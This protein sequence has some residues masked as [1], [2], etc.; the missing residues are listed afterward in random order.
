MW[1]ASGAAQWSVWVWWAVH[2]IAWVPEAAFLFGLMDLAGD[3]VGCMLP[4]PLSSQRLLMSL[5]VDE[6]LPQEKQMILAGAGMSWKP[7][8]VTRCLSL[9]VPSSPSLLLVPGRD[10]VP[11]TIEQHRH[12]GGGRGGARLV[13]GLPSCRSE[14]SLCPLLFVALVFS[15]ILE[16]PSCWPW[17]RWSLKAEAVQ[18]PPDSVLWV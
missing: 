18:D 7:G 9:R 15:H 1:R 11:H 12:D 13:P 8:A 4:Q 5:S 2:W 14:H 10:A 16:P 3:R 6:K 17:W